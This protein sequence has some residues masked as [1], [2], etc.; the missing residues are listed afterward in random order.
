[1]QTVYISNLII[2]QFFTSQLVGVDVIEFYYWHAI[3]HKRLISSKGYVMLNTSLCFT[4]HRYGVYL[5]CFQNDQLVV[6]TIF[7]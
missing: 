6:L 4:A 1:M 7:F 3:K 2:L 5:T